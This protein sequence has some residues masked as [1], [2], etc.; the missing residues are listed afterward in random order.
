MSV[1]LR[2]LWLICPLVAFT[3]VGVTPAVAEE[4]SPRYGMALLSGR[5][6]QP[7][8]FGLL[9]LQGSVQLPYAQ[10]FW[11]DAPDSLFFQG[12]INLGITTDGRDRILA[13]VNMMAVKYLQTWSSGSWT[14]YLEGGVGIIYTDFKVKGQ[15]LRV[16]FNPQIGAGAERLMP[17][18][19]KL[20][21]GL[22][23]HHLSNANLYRDNRGVNS[24]LVLTGVRF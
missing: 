4:S 1:S 21:I 18:G 14:P 19:R 2:L 3:L 16:N 7:E 15:G 6:Y 24:V 5:A 10:V 9:I 17:C 8:R 12:E 20:A 11:H 23:L 13:A 22:R